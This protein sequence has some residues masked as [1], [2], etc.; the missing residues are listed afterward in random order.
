MTTDASVVSEASFSPKRPFCT[1]TGFAGSSG[2]MPNSPGGSSTP[3]RANWPMN[4]GRMPVALG[5]PWIF[6]STTPVWTKVKMS[7]VRISSSSMP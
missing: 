5:S 6:P 7:W 1:R 3:A 2:G 4:V